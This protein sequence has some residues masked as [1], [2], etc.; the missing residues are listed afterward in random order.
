MEL[1]HFHKH[2]VKKHKKKKILNKETSQIFFRET[3]FWMNIFIQCWTQ[4]KIRTLF[5]IFRK[6]RV[7]LPSTVAKYEST[8]LNI[9]KYPWKYLNKLFWQCQDNIPDHLICVKG[10]RWCPSSKCTSFLYMVR[11][12]MQGL[13]VVLDMSQY[14]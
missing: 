4:S 9:A 7:D 5:S 2:S 8:S 10:F 14:G 1:R 3:S 12:F 13:H 11:L 6:R